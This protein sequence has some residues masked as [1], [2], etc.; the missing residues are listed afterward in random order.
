MK[1]RLIKVYNLSMICLVKIYFFI[2]N[3]WVSAISKATWNKYLES[4][5]YRERKKIMGI[6]LAKEQFFKD[7]SLIYRRYKKAVWS[8][9]LLVLKIFLIPYSVTLK[10]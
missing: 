6:T 8:D 4:E 10:G 3:P 5:M 1:N 7:S 2:F 9:K